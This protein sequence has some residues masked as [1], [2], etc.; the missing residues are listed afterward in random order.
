[1]KYSIVASALRRQKP[2]HLT[3]STCRVTRHLITEKT[4]A[5]ALPVFPFT[6]PAHFKNESLRSLTT[7]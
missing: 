6:K 7:T 2:E 1:M 3:Y 4:S 5:H